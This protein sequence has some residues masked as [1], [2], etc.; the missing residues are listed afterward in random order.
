VTGAGVTGA[1]VAVARPGPLADLVQNSKAVS[2]S[3]AVQNSKAVS[4]SKPSKSPRQMA[5]KKTAFRVR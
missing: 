3:K 1:G 2:N 4:N 5:Q